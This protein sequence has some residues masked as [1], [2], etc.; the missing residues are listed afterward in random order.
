MSAGT[1]SRRDRGADKAELRRERRRLAR[2]VAG[3]EAAFAAE[4]A[5]VSPAPIGESTGSNCV[6]R[7][8]SA[9]TMRIWILPIF[10]L[11]GPQGGLAGGATRR[12]PRRF[13]WLRRSRGERSQRRQG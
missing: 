2:Q 11:A 9:P 6:R 4:F 10:M 13:G 1:P 12:W 3:L 5:L 8:P 7:S